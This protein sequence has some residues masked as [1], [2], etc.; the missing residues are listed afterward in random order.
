[1]SSV[2]VIIPVRNR[3]DLLAETL[4]SIKEESD[5]EFDV[6]VV[7]D[8]SDNHKTLRTISEQ[9]QHP[10]TL[11]RQ[12]HRGAPA[13]RNLGLRYASG[14]YIKFLDSDDL[15]EPG[16]LWEQ[17]EVLDRCSGPCVVYSDWR[18][19]TEGPDVR[20]GG[21]PV[22]EM[23]VIECP[24]DALLDDWWCASFS[25]MYNRA[26]LLGQQWDESLEAS[27]DFDFILRVAVAGARFAYLPQQSGRYRLSTSGQITSDSSMVIGKLLSRRRVLRMALRR[28]QKSNMLTS[29]RKRLLAEQFYAVARPLYRLE[30]AEFDSCIEIVNALDP[31]F[32][33]RRAPYLQQLLVRIVGLKKAE[34]IMAYRRALKAAAGFSRE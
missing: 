17:A 20:V 21:R 16:I 8:G 34:R 28:L 12:S 29:K 9:S 13:A 15:L 24:I 26:A 33:P 18:F 5:F 10:M 14:Q 1:M 11:L 27:Q 32:V 31:K 3:F 23:G 4:Q 7:D 6:I 22:R 2:T 19:L 30:E 25:Y